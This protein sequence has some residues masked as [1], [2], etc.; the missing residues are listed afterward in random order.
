MAAAELTEKVST[1]LQDGSLYV[2]KIKQVTQSDWV[3]LPDKG[4][5]IMSGRLNTGAVAALTRGTLT[6][7]NKGTA[8]SA[9]TT[10]IVYDGGTV[11]RGATSFYVETISGEII[12]VIDSAP[13]AAGGTLTVKKRGAFGTTAS[14]TGLADDNTLYVMNNIIL[15]DNQTG[16]VTVLYKPMPDDPNT[17]LFD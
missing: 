11:T 9:T 16:A 12:E 3:I 5:W 15:G 7:N 2:T 17:G 1:L 4:L 13:T 8:Y 10:S 14:L 6:V